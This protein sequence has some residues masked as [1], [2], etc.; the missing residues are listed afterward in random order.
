MSVSSLKHHGLMGGAIQRNPC[1]YLLTHTLIII[2]IVSWQM[3]GLTILC[4]LWSWEWKVFS[5]SY[6]LLTACT[7]NF[8]PI[9]PLWWDELCPGLWWRVGVCVSWLAWRRKQ[10]IQLIINR[11]LSKSKPFWQPMTKKKSN[12][13]PATLCH[14]FIAHSQQLLSGCLPSVQSTRCLN[15]L[16]KYFHCWFFLSFFNTAWSQVS[17]LKSGEPLDWVYSTLLH[18]PQAFNERW[19][20][21]R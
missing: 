19:L 18:I 16:F 5:F 3:F 21:L 6:H 17:L 7:A 2:F 9:R 10:M 12:E 1:V 15:R 13:L 14:I 4:T 8:S 11:S 20:C